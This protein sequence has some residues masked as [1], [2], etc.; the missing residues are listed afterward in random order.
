[1]APGLVRNSR[2]KFIANSRQSLIDHMTKTGSL[3]RDKNR[4]S[5]K[6]NM[7]V[8]KVNKGLPLTDGLSIE[9]ETAN[10][11]FEGN[12]PNVQTPQTQQKESTFMPS[13]QSPQT[14]ETQQKEMTLEGTQ[15]NESTPDPPS[16]QGN[17]HSQ[18]QEDII[19]SVNLAV[20]GSAVVHAPEF[21]RADALASCND[22]KSPALPSMLLYASGH[23]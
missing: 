1:M 10:P 4:Q 20:V 19:A 7:G 23:N 18:S 15:Q 16:H 9:T 13:I 11:T 8:D 14:H 5:E 21:N 6:T 12:L 17:Q 22:S 3:A 2:T